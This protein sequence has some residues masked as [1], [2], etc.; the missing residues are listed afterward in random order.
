M[1]KKASEGYIPV[2]IETKKTNYGKMI[3]AILGIA[4]LLVVGYYMFGLPPELQQYIPNEPVV[5]TLRDVCRDIIKYDYDYV[6]L[7]NGAI[8]VRNT[9]ILEHTEAVCICYNAD[10]L[11]R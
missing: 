11:A 5:Y 4:V 8:C 6:N 7:A 1:D 9:Q 10:K 2:A 3:L